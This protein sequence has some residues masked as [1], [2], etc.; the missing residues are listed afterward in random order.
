MLQWMASGS[1][2]NSGQTSRT[3][4]HSVITK[5][6]RRR[7]NSLRC[8]DRLAL[9]SMP[10]WRMTRTAFGWTGFGWLPAL[11][12]STVPFESEWSSASA[13][14]DRAPFPVQRKRTRHRRVEPRAIARS[15]GGKGA[16][17]N[18]GCSAAPEPR[19]SSLQ[20]AR[21]TA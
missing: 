14:C 7:V 17:S 9:I 19:R 11:M 6:N 13:I 10:R 21:S 12:T 15:G 8:L 18:P 5:S 3:R 1:P 2:G 20:R 16:S 4:S